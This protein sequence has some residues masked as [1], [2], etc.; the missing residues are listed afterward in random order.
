M[1]SLTLSMPKDLKREMEEF[2]E[3]NWSV[4]ARE[5]IRRKL[6]LLKEMDNLFSKSKLNEKDAID[7]GRKINKGAAKR[8]LNAS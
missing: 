4:I 7:L 1:V 3:I 8:F 5:A 6:L 2:P